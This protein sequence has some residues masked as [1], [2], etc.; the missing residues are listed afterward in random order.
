VKEK[1]KEKAKRGATRSGTGW[2]VALALAYGARLA[3]LDIPPEVLAGAAVAALEGVDWIWDKVRGNKD[4]R[5][6]E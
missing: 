5:R 3:G 6:V 1:T 2:T 4:E